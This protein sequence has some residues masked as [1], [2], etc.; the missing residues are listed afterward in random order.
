MQV[1]Q[2]V[3]ALYLQQFAERRRDIS[4]LKMSF[5]ERRR[6]ISRLKMSFHP[7]SASR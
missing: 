6:D 4:R 1:A 2:H 7:V 5:A 3:A